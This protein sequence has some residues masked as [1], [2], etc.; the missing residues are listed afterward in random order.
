[1]KKIA[2][3]LFVLL[4]SLFYAKA[5][6]VIEE[7][8]LSIASTYVFYLSNGDVI[9]AEVDEIIEDKEFGRGVKLEGEFGKMIIYADEISSIRS[10]GNY[11]RHKYRTLFLPTAFP[12]K[13][14]H[15]IG[16]SELAL[17]NAGVG[18]SKYLSIMASHSALPAT[19]YDSQV[20]Y[21]NA[22]G[23]FFNG[24]IDDRF[25]NLAIAGGMNYARIGRDGGMIH[26]FI[27]ASLEFNTAVISANVFTK[28][29]DKDIYDYRIFNSLWTYP[30]ANGTYGFSLSID[31][32]ISPKGIHAFLEV[33]NGDIN[34]YSK[35]S[36]ISGVRFSNN[37]LAADVG[38]GLIGGYPVPLMQF[39]WTPFN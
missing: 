19:N 21:V 27:G 10:L 5:K 32:E 6:D 15:F 2:L 20:W 16:L 33:L 4:L 29:G 3:Y 8:N 22:K 12:I 35:T 1:M 30:Y 26:A 17:V 13:D 34:N 36:L 23:T 11:Y 38:L 14:D 28:L 31:K 9:T 18:I 37:R 24:R 39:F 25:G 7:A